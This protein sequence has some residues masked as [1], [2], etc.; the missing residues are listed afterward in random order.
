[1][2][3]IYTDVSD[4]RSPFRQVPFAGLGATG[5]P[6]AWPKG[7]SYV[8]V[9]QHRMP[10]RSG[11]YQDNTL[12]GLG[13]LGAL[14]G[15][16]TPIPAPDATPPPPVSSPTGP[17]MRALTQVIA[18][19]KAKAAADAKLIADAAAKEA[20]DAKAAADAAAGPKSNTL[21]WLGVGALVVGGYFVFRK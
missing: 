10:Y 13:D 17:R 7:R 14:G 11:Y 21:L 5:W 15:R 3:R 20:A 4:F 2:N 16:M 18:D 9:A 1:M 8:D 12:F 6:M 19:A